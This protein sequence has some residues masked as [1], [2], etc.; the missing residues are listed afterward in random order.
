[1]SVAPAPLRD[2]RNRFSGPSWPAL[3]KGSIA[4]VL[5][6]LGFGLVTDLL[7]NPVF[8]RMVPRSPLDYAF[9]V[10]TAVLTGAYFAQTVRI[11]GSPGD[12]GAI[13]GALGG[14]LA[15]GCPLCNHVLLLLLSGSAIMTYFDPLRP[16]LGVASVGLFGATLLYR[17]RRAGCES[18][19]E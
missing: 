7:P 16:V 14:F 5:T 3:K 8:A 2:V 13:A 10:L 9:L 11:Q 15:F 1:M 12:N 19:S 18:C 4:A 6:F 17:R